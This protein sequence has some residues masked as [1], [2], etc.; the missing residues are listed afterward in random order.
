MEER[1]LMF[2]L[3]S[4]GL[5][6]KL[7]TA[8][9]CLVPG[10]SCK[11]NLVLAPQ[12]DGDWW[13]V[14]GDPDLGDFTN[15]KQ[16]PVDFGVWQAAD[17]TWQLW[18]CIR[19]TKCGG[20]TR[21][22]YRWE[23][24]HLTD[25]DW[26]PMGIAMQAKTELGETEGGLQA[27][28][29]LK[30]AGVYHMFYG[31]WENICLATG[32]DG[33]TFTRQLTGS[34]KTGMFTEGPG[35][36]TR[37]PMVLPVDDLYYCYYTAYPNRQGAVYCRT[38]RD[39]RHWSDSRIVAFGGSAGTGATQSECPFVVYHRESGYYYLFRTQHY[40]GNPETRVYRSKNP[41]EFGI[42][43]DD[44]YLVCILP[45]AAPEIIEYEGDYY[46]ASLLPNL[47]GIRIARLKWVSLLP[48]M[49][50]ERLFNA[51]I[52]RGEGIFNFDDPAVRSGWKVVEGEINPVFTSSKRS[53]FAPIYEH[54]IG[55][56][57]SAAGGPDDAQ[58]GIIESPVFTL[59]HTQYILTVSGG[60]DTRRLYVALVDAETG[61][62]ISRITG[63]NSNRLEDVL[64][65]IPDSKG[66]KAR[67]RIVDNDTGDW[68]HIN[69][70][71]IFT[72]KRRTD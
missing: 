42:N 62:E 33:K 49:R 32:P 28:Y 59:E 10:P 39:L 53:N 11:E 38:S 64:V 17:G 7:F 47:K 22:F 48:D 65:D 52:V 40:A 25:T 45:V 58:Q 71:G 35:N 5:T 18:S 29:V 63:N 20:N 14:A 26:K 70:G 30:I 51:G 15:P 69:F 72:C 13:T 67:I 44:R 19:N 60:M 66:R 1:N 27:P 31:D 46:I 50:G 37:D 57:E 21:L 3:E 12:I 56:A 41:M 16:Q 2:V 54:F 4:C 6:L 55:T 68:G 23:G 24:R 9:W 61:Q 8:L 34:G 36:N 43:R